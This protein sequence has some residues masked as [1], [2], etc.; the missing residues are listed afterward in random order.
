MAGILQATLRLRFN[1]QKY[2]NVM[3]SLKFVVS[4]PVYNKPALI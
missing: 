3:I 2:F 1:E 4:G